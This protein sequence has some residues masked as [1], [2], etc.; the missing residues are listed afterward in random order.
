M[1]V[2]EQAIP[3]R[4][5]NR[6]L[7]RRSFFRTAKD[8][9]IGDVRALPD[10]ILEAAAFTLVVN[11]PLALSGYGKFPV[12]GD[13]NAPSSTCEFTRPDMLF[14]VNVRTPI[15][16]EFDSRLLP[17][18]LFGKNWGVGVA[19]SLYFAYSHG[20]YELDVQKDNAQINI[21]ISKFPLNH[22]ISGAYL[23][24]VFKNRGYLHAVAAHSV[25]NVMVSGAAALG[26]VFSKSE[27]NKGT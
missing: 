16:E 4:S 17:G 27:L 26:C 24:R 23:W 10:T 7:S 22:F 13:T 12:P 6:R 5:F 9:L 18:V 19:T 1:S 20:Q 11:I 14:N 3:I 2:K 21:D 8:T 25:N 15:V